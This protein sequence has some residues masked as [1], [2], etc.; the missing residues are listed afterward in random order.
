MN[1]FL[2]H[3]IEKRSEHAASLLVSMR[4]ERRIMNIFLV[5]DLIV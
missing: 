4:A 1:M 5:H 3:D 2:V